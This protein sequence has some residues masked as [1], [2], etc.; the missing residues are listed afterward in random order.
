MAP[1]K[2]ICV[3]GAST[4]SKSCGLL[5]MSG[6]KTW[7][8]VGKYEGHAQYKHVDIHREFIIC[9]VVNAVAYGNLSSLRRYLLKRIMEAE[10]AM[11]IAAKLQLLNTVTPRCCGSAATDAGASL[12]T[13]GT[14]S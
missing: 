3:N 12:E 8:A 10:T 1:Q 13:S 6:P 7:C 14:L 5:I 4:W 2:A 11:Y 9:S